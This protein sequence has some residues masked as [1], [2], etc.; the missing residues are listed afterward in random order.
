MSKPLYLS[1][2]TLSFLWSVANVVDCSRMNSEASMSETDA[3]TAH[4]KLTEQK[5]R[6]LDEWN[7]SVSRKWQILGGDDWAL[8]KLESERRINDLMVDARKR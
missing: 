1:A 2:F 4:R 8:E 6:K 7:A 5:A 3:Q